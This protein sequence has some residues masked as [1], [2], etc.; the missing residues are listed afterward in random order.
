MA[1]V[2]WAFKGREFVNC[3]A[4]GCSRQF[5]GLPTHGFCQD[6]NGQFAH[7]HLSQ[8]GVVH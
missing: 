1:S 2:K 6:S 4:Y 8:S 5:N 7:I 3:C